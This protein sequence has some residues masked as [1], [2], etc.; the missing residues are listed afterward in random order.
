MYKQYSQILDYFETIGTKQSKQIIESAQKSF[1]SGAISYYFYLQNIDQAFQIDL[2]Y[3]DALKNYNQSVIN[4]L[5]IK[6]EL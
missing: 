3:L 6:G 2:G 4:L 1:R 5:Y